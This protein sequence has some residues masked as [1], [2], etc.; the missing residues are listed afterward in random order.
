[1]RVVMTSTGSGPVTT[2]SNHAADYPSATGSCAPLVANSSTSYFESSNMSRAETSARQFQ[3]TKSLR[4][5]IRQGGSRRSV[6]S[7]ATFCS[8]CYVRF[9]LWCCV[10]AP[11]TAPSATASVTRPTTARV[12]GSASALATSCFMHAH[13]YPGL[14]TGTLRRPESIQFNLD[15]TDRV[16]DNI[17]RGENIE[18]KMNLC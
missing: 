17:N 7:G 9:C 13:M 6:E 16:S 10:V 2:K 3:L 14:P 5:I 8:E 18:I 12:A 1:M 11:V 4:S 15:F